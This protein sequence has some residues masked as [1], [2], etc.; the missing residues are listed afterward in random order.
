MDILKYSPVKH[1][2]ARENEYSC[3]TQTPTPVVTFC[4]IDY[5]NGAYSFIK[6]IAILF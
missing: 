3:Y 6:T 5:V 4:K 2:K 1:T